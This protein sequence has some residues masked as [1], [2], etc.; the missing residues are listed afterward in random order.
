MEGI[1]PMDA[2]L[3]D[4]DRFPLLTE[5]GRRLLTRLREH[6]HAPRWNF[7]CGERL[8][9][10]GLGR[11]RAYA[12]AL[13]TGRTGW[14]PGEAPA[15]VRDHVERCRRGSP[16]YRHHLAGAGEDFFTLPTTRREHLRREPWAFVPD[17]ADL[18]ELVAYTTSGT[19][20]E[21]LLLP[22]H[23]EAPARYLPLY[24]AALAARGIRIDGGDRVTLVHAAFQRR[25]LTYPSVMSYFG[26]AGFAKVNLSPGEWRSPADPARFLE[27]SPEFYTGDP[28]SFAELARLPVAAPKA[29]IST[30]AALLPGLRRQLEG[31]FGCRVLDIYSLNEC[32]PVG[33]DSGDGHELLPHDLFV[34][35]LD[36]QGRPCPPGVRGEITVTGGV[37]PYLPLVRYRT[38]DVAALDC[39][40]PMP[41]LL[42]LEGRR[43][44]VFRTASG[45]LFNSI[46]VST[47]L[48]DLPLPL[49][50]LHQ[51]ADGSLRFRTRCAASAAA[52]AG[53]RLRD[54]FG[55]LP[56]ETEQAP[57]G[58]AWDGKL[59]QY[60]S[61]VAAEAVLSS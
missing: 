39:A 36:A 21:R 56:L 24:E 7:L 35:V 12:D 22:A 50:S 37:N 46:D 17:D 57:D 13:R 9:A 28:V 49:L 15:W 18:T 16:F 27:E 2:P 42:G 31:R 47:T 20:G 53:E 4:S 29:L 40:G 54:L 61:D 44:V 14:R 32:G 10:A 25:T 11:V 30:G 5:A 19:M 48:R 60:H 58:D 45:R 33:C 6:P 3:T 51:R 41:R 1:E 59:I 8:S 52:E 26:S 43:P 34:E 55:G 23:P 38:G